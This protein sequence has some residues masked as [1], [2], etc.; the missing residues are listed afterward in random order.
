MRE[1][2]HGRVHR[3][4]QQDLF[5]RVRDVI[6]AAHHVRHL[7]HHV[8]HDDREVVRGMAVG[9]QHHEVFDGR[10]VEVDRSVDEIVKRRAAIG[11]EES[12]RAW[13]AGGFASLDLGGRQRAARPVVRPGRAGPFGRFAFGFQIL[14]FAVA[15]VGLSAG[16]QPLGRILI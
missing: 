11:H 5:R 16:D 7:H 4:V 3:A 12:D 1:R 13:L 2:R 9:S 15:I 6:V 10:I 14:R 8:V